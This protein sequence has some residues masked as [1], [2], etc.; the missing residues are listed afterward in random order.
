MGNVSWD[1]DGGTAAVAVVE[2]VDV[3]NVVVVDELV[4]KL[5]VVVKVVVV[6]GVEDEVTPES[7]KVLTSEKLFFTEICP[8]NGNE[9]D[10]FDRVSELDD[11]GVV[12]K[13]GSGPDALS[14]TADGVKLS[15]DV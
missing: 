5:L 7:M 9:G 12:V 1:E 3:V 13:E 11:G 2:D 10:S 14:R 4:E 8:G 6:I 15:P